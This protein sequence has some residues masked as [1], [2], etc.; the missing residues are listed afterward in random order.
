M[1]TDVK[2]CEALHGMGEITCT[3]MYEEREG[4]GNMTKGKFRKLYLSKYFL[5]VKIGLGV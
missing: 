5:G 1:G 3:Y 2:S 4:E